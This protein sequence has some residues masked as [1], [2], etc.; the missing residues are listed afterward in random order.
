MTLSGR[1]FQE[2]SHD[3]DTTQ[4]NYFVVKNNK[5]VRQLQATTFGH[6]ICIWCGFY[7]NALMSRTLC[8]DIANLNVEL[9]R[10]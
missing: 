10:S 2:N 6:M 5:D 8:R 1:A 9:N 3:M 7:S 4:S